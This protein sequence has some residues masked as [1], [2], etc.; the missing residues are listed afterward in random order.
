M[1]LPEIFAAGFPRC[2]TTW[3]GKILSQHPELNVPLKHHPIYPYLVKKEIHYFNKFPSD[4]KDQKSKNKGFDRN[5]TEYCDYWKEE[6]INLDLSICSAYDRDSALRVKQILG[7]AKILFFTREKS[8]HQISTR[9]LTD[10]GNYPY[11]S[12]FEKYIKPY[13]D[14]FSSMMIVNLEETKKD[15][16]LALKKIL[17]FIGVKDTDFK[18]DLNE[19]KHSSQEM[20]IA[21]SK[22]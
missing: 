3:I 5:F 15:P 7:D 8:D 11:L 13:Q 22:K 19:S 20:K 9:I 4:L 17:L 18:F 21:R 14:N 6:K 1:I 16:K 10:L 2:G 12:E